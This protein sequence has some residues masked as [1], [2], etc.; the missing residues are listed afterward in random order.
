M[1][2]FFYLFLW[3]FAASALAQD[4][5]DADTFLYQISKP[6]RP[7]SYLLGTIHVG[8]P[9]ATLPA[10]YRHPRPHTPTGGR[11]R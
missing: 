9:N 11:K 3:L 7:V 4:T 8:K 10:A 6:S 2:Y 1:R 5:P